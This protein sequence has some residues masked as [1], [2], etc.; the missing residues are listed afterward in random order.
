[1]D[2]LLGLC[3]RSRLMLMLMLMLWLLEVVEVEGVEL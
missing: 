1:M 3:L 2:G